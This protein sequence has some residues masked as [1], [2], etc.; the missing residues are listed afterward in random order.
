MK[1]I[2]LLVR[3]CLSLF[4]FMLFCKPAKEQQQYSNDPPNRDDS[5]M[6]VRR[7]LSVWVCALKRKIDSPHCDK[8]RLMNRIGHF[9]HI[10][11]RYFFFLRIVFW[12]PPYGTDN[13]TVSLYRTMTS[14]FW[15]MCLFLF[16]E[17]SHLHNNPNTLMLSLTHAIKQSFSI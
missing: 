10:Y 1:A 14:I 15:L 11:S 3:L 2:K 6:C 8:W 13:L 17:Y 5:S 4:L 7:S 12:S 16:A 9:S